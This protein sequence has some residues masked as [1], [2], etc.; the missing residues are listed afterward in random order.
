[1]CVMIL[2]LL[3]QIISLLVN[4]W[5]DFIWIVYHISESCDIYGTELYS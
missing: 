2:I 5:L 3:P 1:M 4:V